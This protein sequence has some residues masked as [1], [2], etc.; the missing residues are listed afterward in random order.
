[1]QQSQ[2]KSV[3]SQLEVKV[4]IP[5]SHTLTGILPDSWLPS[6]VKDPEEIKKQRQ[7]RNPCIQNG[8]V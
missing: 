7:F 1:M 6:R 4:G 3:D 5:R 2:E 8:T